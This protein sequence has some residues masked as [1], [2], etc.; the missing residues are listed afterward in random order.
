MPKVFCI[1]TIVITVTVTTGKEVN[2]SVT[3]RFAAVDNFSIIS[4]LW[5]RILR[6]RGRKIFLD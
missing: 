6:S 2:G 3:C 4:N 5:H 1:E